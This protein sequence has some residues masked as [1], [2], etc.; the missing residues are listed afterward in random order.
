MELFL[1]ENL[2]RQVGISIAQCPGSVAKMAAAPVR[3]RYDR[4]VH[5][6][7]EDEEYP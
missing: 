7:D 2:D 3:G 4:Y 5:V 6:Y 1:F